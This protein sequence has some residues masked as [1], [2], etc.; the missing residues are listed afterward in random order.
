[1]TVV[2]TADDRNGQLA[3]TF[4]ASFSGSVLDVNTATTALEVDSYNLFHY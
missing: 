4:F 2:R 3:V 1:V